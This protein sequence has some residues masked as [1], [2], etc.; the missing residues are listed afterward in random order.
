MESSGKRTLEKKIIQIY[1]MA[2]AVLFVLIQW[3]ETTQPYA[4]TGKI[5]YT[6]III[7]SIIIFIFYRNYRGDV[8]VPLAIMITMVADYNLT[9]LNQF[10]RTG[11]AW[12]VVV[13]IVYA[14]KTRID[15]PSVIL[16]LFFS[17]AY[18]ALLIFLGMD[19]VDSLLCALSMGILT[20]NVIY[21]WKNYGR[22][23]VE[24]RS[25]R[26][27]DPDFLLALGLTLFAGC[28]LSLGLRNVLPSTGGISLWTLLYQVMYYL[29]WICYLPSQVLLVL[30]Y[31]KSVLR[32]PPDGGQVRNLHPA[33]DDK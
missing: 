2:E 22:K 29:T 28:D 21:G 27:E 20:G 4:V 19:R 24:E 8:R 9:Y 12:F 17:A 7:N 32:D 6:A 26:L 13:Q 16:R 15:I 5:M 14:W 3:A 31:L 30:S 33:I 11:V 25:Q 23:T 18:F 10:F 1:L